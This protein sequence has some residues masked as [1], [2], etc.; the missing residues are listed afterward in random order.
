[1]CAL[2]P[3]LLWI[4]YFEH[5]ILYL[6]SGLEVKGDV[7][8]FIPLHLYSSFLIEY[9]EYVD[10]KIVKYWSNKVW[11]GDTALDLEK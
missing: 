5:Y 2:M 11:W 8:T 10:K 1:M 4:K 7:Q 3:R 6:I 9:K